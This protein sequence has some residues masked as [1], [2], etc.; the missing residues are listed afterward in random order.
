[1]LDLLRIRIEARD[2][3]RTGNVPPL[4]FSVFY[5]VLR[6]FLSEV[7][8]AMSFMLDNTLDL[9]NLTTLPAFDLSWFSF[10]FVDILVTL[11]ISVLTAGFFCYCL[12]IQRGDAMPYESLFD[13]FP[14]AGKVILLEMLQGLAIA[15]GMMFFILPG[16]VLAFS[17]ALALPYLCDNPETGVIEALRKSRLTMRGKRIRFFNMLLSFWPLLLVYWFSY[18]LAYLLSQFF[19]DTLA[20][21]LGSTFV[22]GLFRGCAEVYYFPLAYLSTACFYRHAIKPV[23]RYDIDEDDDWT[24]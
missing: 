14:F 7:S 10:S 19:P 23:P 1:M 2:L 5:L 15:A 22:L 17:Y 24:F 20:A 13:A 12:G 3:L 9:E 21:A 8:T 11:I 16:V 18:Q 4:R 6:L